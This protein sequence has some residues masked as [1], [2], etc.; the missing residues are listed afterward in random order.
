M[1]M[2]LMKMSLMIVLLVFII[3]TI[4]ACSKENF[5]I[6]STAKAPFGAPLSVPYRYTTS[7]IN[8][9]IRNEYQLGLPTRQDFIASYG[10]PVCND[11]GV[12]KQSLYQPLP[13]TETGIGVDT[14][15]KMSGWYV[16]PGILGPQKWSF[17]K[18]DELQD[19]NQRT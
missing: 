1:K 9:N 4:K 18:F 2:S 11:T 17:Y 14:T 15:S 6:P 13:P 3:C 8:Y 19:T 10:Y 16:N 5:W 12:R 7:G